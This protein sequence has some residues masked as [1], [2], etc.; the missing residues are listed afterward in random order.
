M[1]K[2]FISTANCGRAHETDIFDVSISTPFTITASG[3]GTIKLWKNKLLDTDQPRDNFQSQFVHK[4]GVHHVDNFHSI[5]SQGIEHLIISCVTFS[6][7]IFFYRYDFANSKL[8]KLELIKDNLLK[9][10]SYWAIKWLKSNDQVLSHRLA[11]TDVKGSTYVWKFHLPTTTAKDEEDEVEQHSINN[12]ELEFQGEIPATSPTFATCVDMAS[13]RGLIATGF[14][15]GKVIVSQLSTLRPLYNFEGFGMKGTEQNSNSVREV[16]FSPAGTLLAVANDSGSFGCVSLYETEFG[17]RVGNL[18]VPTHSNSNESS[19]Q[20]FAH[21]GW[22][23]GLSFNSTGEFLSSCGYD[24]KIRV[25]DVKS[26]ERVTTLNISAEDIE[27]EDEIL[28]NDELGDSLKHPPVLGV[29]Y[30]NKD[31][32]GGMNSEANE[33]L[34][35]VCMDRSVRWFRE[36]GGN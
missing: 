34:C 23:M 27:N 26:K 8:M 7:E 31:V 18:T 22:V 17:E 12:L 6:G 3:D 33:G 14:A 9:K 36:A 2:I 28:L 1:S 19:I 5:D 16:K 4:T 15:D 13:S 10:K 21:S 25:W 11:A 32:R 29:E 35:C 24:S 20:S 30:I